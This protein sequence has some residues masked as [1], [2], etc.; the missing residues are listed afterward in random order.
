MRTLSHVTLQLPSD[1]PIYKNQEVLVRIRNA[2]LYNGGHAPNLR[3][4]YIECSNNLSRTS[5]SSL[6]KP[7]IDEG[8]GEKVLEIGLRYYSGCSA[9]RANIHRAIFVWEMITN[10]EHEFAIPPARV[11]RSLL[12]RAYS[13]LSHAYFELHQYACKGKAVER[14]QTLPQFQHHPLPT[15]TPN[16]DLANDLLYVSALYANGSVQQGLVSP[17][18][19][20]TA[21]LILSLGKRDGVDPKRSVRFRGLTYLWRAAE[22]RAKEYEREQRKQAAKVAKA[23]NAYLCATPGCGIAGNQKKA[24]RKCGG[25]CPKAR[26]PHYCSIECQKK[27]WNSHKP[28]CM[29]DDELAA[30]PPEPRMDDAPQLNA[31]DNA[32]PIPPEIPDPY[33]EGPLRAIEMDVPGQGRVRLESRNLTPAVLRWMRDAAVARSHMT[34]R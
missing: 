29:P 25:P 28:Y 21:F 19:L 27:D 10:P 31:D 11:S 16:P 20:S 3:D 6:F 30:C 13:C 4:Q 32:I 24:L 14:D 9:T 12:A 34:G 8:D 7:G 22:A 2:A 26:K 1:M 18:V 33:Y 15:C 5:L 23:P 17:A